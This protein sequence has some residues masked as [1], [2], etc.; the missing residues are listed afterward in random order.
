MTNA[1]LAD[2]V[3][4]DFVAAPDDEDAVAAFNNI[5]ELA[6]AA[7]AALD[8]GGTVDDARQ[9]AAERLADLTTT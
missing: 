9:A 2:A 8:A 6:A 4:H 3:A 7:L 5:Y 1:E